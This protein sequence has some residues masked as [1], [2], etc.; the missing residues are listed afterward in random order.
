MTPEEKTKKK[1]KRGSSREGHNVARPESEEEFLALDFS[2]RCAVAG[3]QLGRTK[4]FLRREAFDRIEAMRS[5]TFFNAAATIQKIVRGKQCREYFLIMRYAAT[6]IQSLFRMRLS[7]RRVEGERALKSAVT[8]QSAWRMYDAKLSLAQIVYARIAAAKTIQQF[9]RHKQFKARQAE[10]QSSVSEDDILRAVT[11]VQAMYRGSRTRTAVLEMMQE[12]ERQERERIAEE[13]RERI[14]QEERERI[15]QEE[16]MKAE[17]ERKA[18]AEAAASA[19]AITA[20]TT[21]TIV[22]SPKAERQVASVDRETTTA[23]AVSGE[24]ETELYRQIQEEN[25][26]MVENLLDHHPELAETADPK[27]GELPLHM[28]ARHTGA[29]TL[30]IDMVLVLYPKALIHRDKMGALPIHHAAAHDSL[31]ALEII[32]S[33]YKE[34]INDTDRKGRLPI[35]VAAE[36]DAVDTVKFLLGKSPEGAYTMVYRPPN[37]S[38]GGLPLH[39][40]C[41]N[42]ASIGVITALLAENFASAK[43]ADENGDLPLHLLLRCGEVVDQ[44]VVKTLLTCFS[45]AAS[46]TDMNGDLPLAIAIKHQCRS[47]VINTVLMQFPDGAGV[48]NGD[49]HSPLF[50]AFK[51]NADDRTIMGL[52]NHAPEVNL[53]F[54]S[55]ITCSACEPLLTIA[56]S[57]IYSL[58]LPSTERLGCSRFRLRPRMSILTLSFTICSSE[59]CRL[60]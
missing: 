20:A 22:S 49:G 29:W 5:E 38:G 54:A 44:V 23:L 2:S 25:W 10:M 16:R 14:L 39:I 52:L 3:L 42:Y 17:K 9:Y 28:I 24:L 60:T 41:R 40:A 56:S 58:P 48:L 27:S 43:R 15:A 19:A 57:A 12:Q 11:Q 36:F 8:I 47:A 32:Y 34:G 26:A 6:A 45:S 37:N 55:N 51:H 18:K 4:V 59:I 46:R 31:A 30:L 33:A 50:L 35:H 7:L 21:A 53:Y 13:E 1:K